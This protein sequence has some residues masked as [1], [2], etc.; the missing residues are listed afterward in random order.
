MAIN[1]S[2]STNLKYPSPPAHHP[3]PP[4]PHCPHDNPEDTAQTLAWP[5][6]SCLFYGYQD[7]KLIVNY[8]NCSDVSLLSVPMYPSPITAVAQLN[9]HTEDQTE[10]TGCVDSHLATKTITEQDWN[11]SLAKKIWPFLLGTWHCRPWDN[12]TFIYFGL[13]GFVCATR[14]GLCNA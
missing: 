6:P 10:D 9:D 12:R 11:F 7:L 2:N 14:G 4:L 1:V 13:V 8:Q 3:H 5:S